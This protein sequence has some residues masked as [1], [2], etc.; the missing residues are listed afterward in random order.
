MSF[1]LGIVK[2]E[3]IK[4]INLVFRMLYLNLSL[5]LYD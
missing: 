2:D 5:D 4:A 1:V 3:N